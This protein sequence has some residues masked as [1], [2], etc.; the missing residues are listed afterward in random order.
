MDIVRQE[1]AHPMQRGSGTH[2]LAKGQ[3]SRRL[4]HS[5]AGLLAFFLC[6]SV[7]LKAQ[8]PPN[9]ANNPKLEARVGQVPPA[10]SAVQL[11]PRFV[12]MNAPGTFAYI[13]Y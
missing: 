3:F 12:L 13:L 8:P 2:D 4:F 7:C 9:E 6:V 11:P 1:R 10:G 5:G